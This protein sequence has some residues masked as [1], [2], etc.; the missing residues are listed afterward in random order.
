VDRSAT[1]RRYLVG[2]D[3]ACFEHIEPV[4]SAREPTKDQRVFF[5]V[6]MRIEIISG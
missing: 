4:L 3:V 5:C 6:E 1:T 2:T